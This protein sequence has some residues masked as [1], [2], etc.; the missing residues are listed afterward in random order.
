MRSVEVVD[1]PDD[2]WPKR[3]GLIEYVGRSWRVRSLVASMPVRRRL[4]AGAAFPLTAEWATAAWP[5]APVP[6]VP[7]VP[8]ALA[9][10][11]LDG[12]GLRAVAAW[13]LV[14][15]LGMGA[16]AGAASASSSSMTMISCGTP[17]L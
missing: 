8:A 2:S 12:A 7:V 9:A 16:G 11:A 1:V 10:P 13:L 17:F 3:C 5:P 6:A 15:P 14:V 4:L